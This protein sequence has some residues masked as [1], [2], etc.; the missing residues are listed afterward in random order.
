MIIQMIHNTE[1]IIAKTRQ[2]TENGTGTNTTHDV[3]AYRLRNFV[4]KP[5]QPRIITGANPKSQGAFSQNYYQNYLAASDRAEIMSKG[6][7]GICISAA[8]AA[9]I[10]TNAPANCCFQISNYFNNLEQILKRLKNSASKYI[11]GSLKTFNN[12]K[13]LVKKNTARRQRAKM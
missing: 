3:M 11:I 7:T 5:F 9:T 8:A 4:Y 1:T 13:L 10:S 12:F 2:T 6:R